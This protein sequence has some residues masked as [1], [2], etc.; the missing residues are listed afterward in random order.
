MEQPQWLAGWLAGE[1]SFY[2]V[3]SLGRYQTSASQEFTNKGPL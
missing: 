3:N 1:E 2:S